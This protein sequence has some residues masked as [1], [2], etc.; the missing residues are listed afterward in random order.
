MRIIAVTN[1]KG[2]VGKSTSVLNIGAGLIRKGKK[3]LL[4]DLDPQ[5]SLTYSLGIP[6]HELEHSI[7]DLLK[8]TLKPNDVII[9]KQNIKIVPANLEAL[10]NA[11]IEFSNIPGRER[12][13]QEALETVFNDYDYVIIDCPPNLGLL[14]LN[15]LT[16][17]H[18]IY[19]PL[20]AEYLPM[21]GLVKLMSTVELVQKRL[22][23]NIEVT[24]IIIT[25]FNIRKNLN[26]EVQDELSKHFGDK[27]FKTTI[28]DNI[29]LAESPSA[30]QD[31]FS[32]KP[33]SPGAEDYKNLVDEILRRN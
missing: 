5:S 31:I 8:G 23:Q 17:A 10:A 14:T 7:Y 25:R 20:T 26:K 6:A 2:G 32:Y 24:G 15:A 29:A 28:R 9:E 22:N 33:S 30:G 4:V 16:T 19:I 12:L 11:D 3:V 18:E 27:L 1:Q 21:Q 13:L